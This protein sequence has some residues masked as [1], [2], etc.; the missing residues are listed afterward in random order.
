LGTGLSHNGSACLL[1]DG[2]I[3]VAI[4][5]ERLTRKKHDG[6]NDT[7]AINYCLKAAG[8]T[9]RDVALV[10]Q[11][12][13]NTDL[14]GCL[15]QYAG[16]RV[17]AGD[18]EVPVVTISHH[19]A[20]AYS[21]IGT[22]PFDEFS[23]LIIDGMGNSYDACSD[24]A[25][26]FVPD[27]P[28]VEQFAQ[29]FFE[30]DSYYEYTGGRCRTVMKDFSE[31]GHL[32]HDYP[33]H[34]PNKHS[35]GAMY[36]AA[37]RYCLNNL[38]D[39]GKLMGLGPY[40]R[41]GV[42]GDEIFDLRDGRVFVNYDWMHKFQDRVR[43]RGDFDR[44]FQYYADIAY[45]VQR[46]VERA[47]FYIVR[48]RLARNGARRLCYAGGVALN[49]V[50]NARLLASGLV[51]D[52]Y[53]Q[54]AAGDNGIAI[55]CAYYGWLEVLKE[56]RRPQRNRS[57]CFGTTYDATAIDGAV[58]AFSGALD[59]VFRQ[60]ITA[61]TPAP[62]AARRCI[63]FD[64]G[65]GRVRN[66]VVAR[67][68]LLKYDEA[69]RAAPTCRVSIEETAFFQF[70]FKRELREA[71]LQSGAIEASDPEEFRALIA[72]IN[73]DV[74]ARQVTAR[75]RERP[76]EVIAA[77][78]RDPD[79]IG[80]TADLLANGKI[81][82]W[83][84]D[85]SEFGP[86]ALGHRSILADPRRPEVRDFIN[87]HIKL[88]EDFRPFAPSVLLEDAPRYF[89]S[90]FESPYM[91]LVDQIRD[92]WR[93]RVPSIVHEDGS[94]RVQTVTPDWNPKYAALLRE[95][96]SRTGLSILLNTSFNGRGMPIVETPHD[97]LQ[98]FLSS[99]LDALTIGEHVIEKRASQA[100]RTDWPS[101]HVPLRPTAE[102]NPAMLAWF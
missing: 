65:D 79:V 44:N 54:P 1:K 11:N 80:R 72:M 87:R 20:H 77:G 34:P 14:R 88:R 59:V 55:G 13:P 36:G 46:E 96:R 41:P 26:A 78:E 93:D 90:A 12:S 63:Q 25:G 3:C 39:L 83:F 51:D 74:L 38:N 70:V 95:F 58:R 45:W 43:S 33:M 10:V 98:F 23:V 19:L 28:L 9:L 7:E 61:Y 30:K 101:M 15:K 4:E 85:G 91:L 94:C 69:A 73:W 6:Y 53:I 5:K 86:R 22:C 57:T 40:G 102:V 16:V 32:I 82:A 2:E 27:R 31:Y 64:F 66:L 84:Q 29:V 97:A 48:E 60:T 100:P 68:G 56:E 37:S 99:R 50:A 92:E 21:T 81:V 35:I 8:I 89:Q 17:F 47:L 75:L 76:D 24:L 18:V 71:L 67:N 49:A 42:H 62:A 52:L